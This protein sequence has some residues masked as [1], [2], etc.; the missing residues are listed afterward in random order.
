MKGNGWKTFQIVQLIVFLCFS[1]FLFVRA[2]DGHGAAQTLEAKLISFAVWGIFYLGVLAVEW[3]IYAIVRRSKKQDSSSM[4]RN[5][6]NEDGRLA[7]FVAIGAVAG[8]FLGLLS[9]L[10]SGHV[11]MGIGVGLAIGAGI[12]AVFGACCGS[13]SK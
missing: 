3:L 12:G 7:M 10:I 11:G 2:V 4:E 5:E 9:G 6:T 13:K 8:A 1:V